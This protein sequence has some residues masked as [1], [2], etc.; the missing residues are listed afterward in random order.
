MRRLIYIWATLN[1]RYLKPLIIGFIVYMYCT[2][3]YCFLLYKGVIVSTDK[4]IYAFIDRMEAGWWY[5]ILPYIIIGVLVL[6]YVGF[7]KKYW[8]GIILDF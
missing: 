3:L 7:G 8:H 1:A 5:A 6:L 2:L 4:H